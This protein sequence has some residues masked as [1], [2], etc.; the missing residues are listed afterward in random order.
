MTIYDGCL[1]TGKR[2]FSFDFDTFKSLLEEATSDT[3]YKYAMVDISACVS[4]G[5][6]VVAYETEIPEIMQN[7]K[8]K[9]EFKGS[10]LTRGHN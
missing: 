8:H 10:D 1:G 2:I 9:W 3:R 4:Y 5:A 7:Y 6:N